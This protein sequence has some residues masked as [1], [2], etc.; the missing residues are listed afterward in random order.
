MFLTRGA[1]ARM[2]PAPLSSTARAVTG[3]AAL[4]VLIAYIDW[5]TAPSF[6]LLYLFPVLLVG[7]VLAVALFFGLYFS[8]WI[9][10]LFPVWV[11]ALSLYLLV[12]SRRAEGESVL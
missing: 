4:V 3:A 10:L 11:F 1:P 9:G 6:G 12:A 7:T 8:Q 2:R 5:Q